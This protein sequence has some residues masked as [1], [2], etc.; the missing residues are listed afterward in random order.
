MA[1]R[2]GPVHPTTDDVLGEQPATP[3]RH[4]PCGARHTHIRRQP[5]QS[6]LHQVVREHLETFLAEARAR[7][8]GEGLP[9]FVERELREFITC[10]AMARGFARFRCDG[11]ERE[12]LVAFSCK[13]HI[14]PSCCGRRMAELAAHLVD[15]VLGGLPVRQWVLTLPF[16]L[17]Y[18]LAYDHRLCRAVLGVFVRALLG[19]EQRRARVL[20]VRGRAGS[21]TAIQRCGSALNAN[22]HFHTLLA[23]GVFEEQPDGSHRF[24]PLREPP[25]DVEV[26]RLLAAVRGRIIHL[27]R[28]HDIDLEGS[29][30]DGR[31]DPLALESPVLAQVQG[32]SVLGRVATGPRAGQRVLRLGSDPTAPPV[33]TGGPRHAH[34]EGFDLHA[35]AAVRAGENER[36]EHLCRY[37]LRPPVAQDAL[38][39]TPDGKVLLRLRRP[40]RDGTRAICFEPSEFLE[41]LAVIIPRPRINLLLYH[42]AFAPRGRCHSGP[43]VVEDAPH[44][45]PTPAS[46][47][48]GA[49]PAPEADA[50]PAAAYVRPRYVAWADL[51]AQSVRAGHSGLPRLR[52]AAASAGD[53]RGPCGGR[54][55]PDAPRVARRSAVPIAGAHARVAPGR[56]RCSR[57]RARRRRP[58][59]RLTPHRRPPIQTARPHWRYGAM[60]A[61]GLRSWPGMCFARLTAPSGPAYRCGGG[62]QGTRGLPGTLRGGPIRDVPS[63]TPACPG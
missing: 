38:E 33:T 37:I 54:E 22:P 7:G 62:G 44:R 45:V 6:V 1:T 59:D 53:D 47:S 4:S 5:A 14:C 40:W 42:G 43:V 46:G 34:I 25:T 32:A 21:V 29:S 31:S 16:R 52:R 28:R 41:K 23:E 63:T 2:P 20:G 17:R 51:V 60:P 18:R 12:I 39:W 8:G 9:R 19:F 56:A 50:T 57:S 13:G 30:D 27:L 36:L 3:E 49:A 55:D 11:C 35:N 26:A 61:G 15:G 24:V 58:L 48:A 10:G